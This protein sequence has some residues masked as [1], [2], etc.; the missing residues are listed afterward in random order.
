MDQPA[1]KTLDANEAFRV[2]HVTRS[3]LRQKREAGII[4]CAAI[5]GHDMYGKEYTR[6]LYDVEDIEREIKKAMVSVEAPAPETPAPVPV[7]AA[8]DRW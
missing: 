4:R 8:A 3:W 5:K 2:Y 7:D 1:P 6:Y